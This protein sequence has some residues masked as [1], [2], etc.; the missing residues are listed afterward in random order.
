MRYELTKEL[1]FFIAD[2]P[3]TNRRL[4]AS[5]RDV[6]STSSDARVTDTHNER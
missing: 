2:A 4:T 5:F 6:T 3:S 1:G